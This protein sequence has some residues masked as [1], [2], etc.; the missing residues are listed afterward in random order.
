[1]GREKGFR[2][3]LG[4]GRRSFHGARLRNPV[5]ADRI[6]RDLSVPPRE[7]ARYRGSLEGAGGGVALF[8][9]PAGDFHSLF[10]WRLDAMKWSWRIGT[11]AGIGIYVHATFLLILLWAGAVYYRETQSWAGV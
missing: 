1:R 7:P 3:A 10:P 8:A 11:V 6:Q 9:A 5:A 2:G 4:R